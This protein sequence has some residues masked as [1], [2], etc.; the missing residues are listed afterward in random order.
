VRLAPPSKR[1]GAYF[2]DVLIPTLVIWIIICGG[3]G[4]TLGLAAAS[5]ETVGSETAAGVAVGVGTLVMLFCIFGACVLGAVAV[6][7]AYHPR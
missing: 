7:P 2:F 5:S 1:L 4:L 3:G 6:R